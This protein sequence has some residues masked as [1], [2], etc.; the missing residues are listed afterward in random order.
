MELI[1]A[2][3]NLIDQAE[4][5]KYDK[6]DCE[7]SNKPDLLEHTWELT[8]PLSEFIKLK[9]KVGWAIYITG[10]E[11]GGVIDRLKVD[12]NVVT[13]T[14]ATWEGMLARQM[15]PN[16]TTLSSPLSQ[17]ASGAVDVYG[18][19]QHVL[20][21]LI[22]GGPFYVLPLSTSE[23]IELMGTYRYKTVLDVLK[24]LFGV[25]GPRGARLSTKYDS[26][27]RLVFVRAVKG[28]NATIS[29]DLSEDYGVTITR[30]ID[31]LERYN[32]IHVLG[33]GELTSRVRVDI[34]RTIDGGYTTLASSKRRILDGRTYIYDYNSLT[35]DEAIREGKKKLQEL[36]MQSTAQL[37]IPLS[38]L[39][40]ELCDLVSATDHITGDTITAT[41]DRKILRMTPR[42]VLMEY[43][44]STRA[45]DQYLETG[46]G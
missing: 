3:S 2:D 22:R 41:I 12:D 45:E 14:G 28:R 26:E 7:I 18:F 31:N 46:N 6:Y 15:A 4:I 35:Y 37:N 25:S 16:N 20:R 17:N 1:L 43:Q 34:W 9:P 5:T 39:K 23:D 24:Q 42:Q 19:A 30:V 44:A 8:L 13:L 36:V 38:D 11:Y 33:S 40:L 21:A 10:Q 32:H 29:K 27:S